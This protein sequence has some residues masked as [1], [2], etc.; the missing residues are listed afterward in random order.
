[1]PDVPLIVDRYADW[2]HA[3]EY[4]REHSRTAA[5][6]ADWFDLMRR[7]IAATAGVPPEQVVIKEK[8]RQRG[9]TQHEKVADARRTLVVTEGTPPLKFEINL[10][11]YIDTGLFL[12]H[13]LT[14][15]MVRAEAARKRFLNLFCYTGAFTVHAAAGGAAASTSVDLSNTYLDWAQRNLGLNNL[16]SKAHTLVRSDVLDFLRAHPRHGPAYDLVVCDPPTFSNSKST[17]EDWEVARAHT[18]VL[19]LLAPLVSPGGVVYF[20]TNYRRF[21]LDDRAVAEAGWAARNISS[22]TVPPEYRNRR[23]HLC[24]RMVNVGPA[25]AVRALEER[26]ARQGPAPAADDDADSHDAE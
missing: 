19:A 9:L 10:T 7:T 6:Q 20:S 12:D 15:D 8:H 26:L 11:D 21:K 5:Q 16:W 13:R 18:E 2:Y 4:E 14:R 3:A 22:R 1:V 23:I 25:E 17:Q 24:W